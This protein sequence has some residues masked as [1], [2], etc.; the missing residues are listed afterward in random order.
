MHTDKMK[1]AVTACVDAGIGLTAMKT[2]ANESRDRFQ[3]APRMTE[4]EIEQLSQ[5]TGPGL[6]SERFRRKSAIE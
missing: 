3:G 5:L 2:V 4:A 6:F 1:K